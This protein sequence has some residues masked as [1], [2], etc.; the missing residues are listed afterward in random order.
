MTRSE[1]FLAV[2]D[3]FGDTQ[4]RALVRELVLGDLGHYTAE[5]ALDDGVAPKQVWAAL[6]EAMGVPCERQHGVGQ[7]QPLRDT[8]S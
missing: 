3:E 6:C 8:P 5:A 2:L 4:G 1:F 7:R